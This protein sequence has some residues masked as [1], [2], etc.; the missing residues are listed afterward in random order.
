MTKRSSRRRTVKR[1]RGGAN[2]NFYS[3]NIH[4]PEPNNLLRFPQQNSNSL[5]GL[6]G[7][8]ADPEHMLKRQNAQRNLKQGESNSLWKNALNSRKTKK[9]W[10]NWS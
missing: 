6:K 8:F 3:S 4:R 7:V 10:W 2:S 5:K 1:R 9:A